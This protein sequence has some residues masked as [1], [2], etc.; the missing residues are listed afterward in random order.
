MI[1]VALF[2]PLW[3]RVMDQRVLD[4]YDGDALKANLTP[5]LRAKHEAEAAAAASAGATATARR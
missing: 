2:P 3:R 4:H 5:K 1:V